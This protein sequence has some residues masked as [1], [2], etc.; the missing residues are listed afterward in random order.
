M[1]V[2][3]LD[4]D[5]GLAGVELDPRRYCK[6]CLEAAGITG[7][8]ESTSGLTAETL[9]RGPLPADWELEENEGEEE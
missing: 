2:A 1:Q 7:Y 5:G 9:S 6:P 8:L 3:K 4:S